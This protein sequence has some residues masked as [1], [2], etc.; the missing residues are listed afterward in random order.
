MIKPLIDNIVLREPSIT[1]ENIVFDMK[2]EFISTYCKF[3]GTNDL[4]LYSDYI[5]WL[6]HTIKQTNSATFAEFDNA[7][8]L[9]YLAIDSTS[10]Q[11]IGM[12]E[13]VLYTSSHTRRAHVIICVR[14]SARRKGYGKVLTKKSIY[15]CNS[16]GVRKEFITFEHNSKASSD[17]MSKII[18]F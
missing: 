12:I 8:K 15:E 6:A 4:N 17:T 3:N 10:N 16:L 11:L 1:D 13:I 18:D 7:V 5:E 2:K 14:P 9:T